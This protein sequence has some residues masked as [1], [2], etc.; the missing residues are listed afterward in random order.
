MK[1]VTD[2]RNVCISKC[3]TNG[4]LI[5]IM[6]IKGDNYGHNEIIHNQGE[7]LDVECIKP[8]NGF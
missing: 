6:L 4:Q 1:G 3:I 8:Q 7:L 5:K 2:V